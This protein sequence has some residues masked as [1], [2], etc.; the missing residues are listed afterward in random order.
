ML[1]HVK[2]GFTGSAVHIVPVIR[3]RKRKSAHTRTMDTIVK[4][5]I[6]VSTVYILNHKTMTNTNVLGGLGV[7]SIFSPVT[8]GRTLFSH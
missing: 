5:E 8:V 6:T 3:Q 1:I 7:W 2:F 4:G